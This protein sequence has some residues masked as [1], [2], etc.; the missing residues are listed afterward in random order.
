VK[1]ELLEAVV[2]ARAD[3]R[4]VVLV[5]ALD[6][7]ERWLVGDDGRADTGGGL[8]SAVLEQCR[9]ALR[10]DGASTIEAGGRQYLLQ[11]LSRPYRLIVVG[12]VHIAQA[13][14]PMA[15]QAGY[16]TLLIDPRPAFASADRFP[17]TEIRND[18]PQE[19]FPELGLDSRSAVVALSH[20]PKID[21]PALAAALESEAFY[22]GALGSKKNHD[23]RIAR[24][25]ER[26][27]GADSLARIAGPIGL[28]LGGRAPAEIAVAILAQIIQARYRLAAGKD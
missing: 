10:R 2:R 1:A 9:L 16:E 13:L 4:P 8:P 17:G 18:W 23:S 24:L 28:P 26:G 15:R 21:E 19:V 11:T 7:A 20:D 3:N 5:R 12:A 14:I 25:G 22:I 27:Y 6:S